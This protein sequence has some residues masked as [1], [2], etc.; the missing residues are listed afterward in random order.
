MPT[1][2]D[3]NA[4]NCNNKETYKIYKH[5]YPTVLHGYVPNK[6]WNNAIQGESELITKVIFDENEDQNNTVMN[7]KFKTIGITSEMVSMYVVAI[8]ESHSVTEKKIKPIQC[9]PVVVNVVSSGR[10]KGEGL[11]VTGKKTQTT[12]KTLIYRN[13]LIRYG[14]KFLFLN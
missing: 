14:T 7:V 11:G 8:R 10:I 13:S 9:F 1:A 2:E 3:H 6:K 4:R 5:K 12:I